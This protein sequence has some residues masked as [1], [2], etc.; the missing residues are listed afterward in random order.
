VFANYVD[1]TDY[2]IG[3]GV[4]GKIYAESNHV[5]RTKTITQ[6]F[7]DSNLTWT[8]SNFY[9]VAT[10]TRANS[11]GS[12]MSDWLRADGG[13]SP[14]PYAYSAGSASSTPPSST[15]DQRQRPVR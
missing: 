4:S 8:S 5:K 6:D 9:D 11:S 1:V 15:S 2:F 3:L 12:T 10:I 13:V 7:G 14:P